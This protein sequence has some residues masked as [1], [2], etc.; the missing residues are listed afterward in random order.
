MKLLIIA[1]AI[2]LPLPAAAQP[3]A[4]LTVR[5]VD[6]TGLPVEGAEVIVQA[7]AAAPV[8]R[9]TDRPGLARFDVAAGGLTITANFE[10]F[11]PVTRQLD[12]VPAGPLEIA[13]EP[14]FTET[15]SVGARAAAS[16]IS[17]MLVDPIDLPQSVR[18]IDAEDIQLLGA[19]RIADLF[20]LSGVTQI[21]TNGGTWDNYS[22]RGFSGDVNTGPDLLI[23]RFN[24]NRGFNASR[25]ALT[26]SRFEV[27]KGPASAL[28]GKG[29]PGGSINIVTKAG[30]DA[31][32]MTGEIRAGNYANY[33]A[34]VDGAAPV[35]HGVSLRLVA[36]QEENES[37]RDFVTS[38]RR[39]VAPTA[40]WSASPRLKFLYQL[41]LSEF[42]SLFDRGVVNVAGNS[43]ALPRTRFL[44]E[45]N[46][47]LVVQDSVQHQGTITYYLSGRVAIEAGAQYRDGSLV[48]FLS[49]PNFT[50][51]VSA[52]TRLLQR[53]YRQRDY[54]FA[55]WSGRVEASVHGRWFGVSHQVRAGVDALDYEQT[56]I[57]FASNGTGYAINIDQPIYGQAKP[58]MTRTVADERLR[59]EGYFI[60]D[61]LTI[62]DHVTVVAGLRHDRLRQQTVATSATNAITHREQSPAATSPRAALTFAPSDR[63]STY[64]SWGR[65]FRYNQG[66]SMGG[67]GNPNPLGTP[68]EPERGQAWE[69]GIK[70][71]FD[72][73]RITGTTSLFDIRKRNVLVAGGAFPGSIALGEARSRGVET[74]LNWRLIDRF[75]AT[76]VYAY[77][78]AETAKDVN[79]LLVSR[80]LN[81]IPRHAGSVFVRWQSAPAASRAFAFGAGVSHV[82]DRAAGVTTVANVTTGPGRLPAYTVAQAHVDYWITRRFSVRFDAENLF[83]TYFLESSNNDTRMFPGT[84]RSVALTLRMRF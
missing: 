41:E 55:D 75:Y 17:G 68:F 48:G 65:S 2:L 79:P 81:N 15:V 22:I 7:G 49:E 63:F 3:T 50:G 45:P 4:L 56:Q 62:G 16:S 6:S 23:N 18:V 52:T 30:A 60:Q 76:A 1:L 40:A 58:P 72:D 25:D 57:N 14:G 19:T 80:P 38:N 73:G 83:D 53:T 20:S 67:A 12:G 26:V 35:G 32:E 11:T 21:N 34:A 44:G 70:Y 78:D 43:K 8:T 59:G 71:A 10:G 42:K 37:F 64:V 33:R 28:S 39:L 74:D 24:S 61:L 5:V 66:S 27:L 77:V 29:E 46:D 9:R 54:S 51:A 69:G 13:L 82:G 84:P 36:V 47:G 31:P